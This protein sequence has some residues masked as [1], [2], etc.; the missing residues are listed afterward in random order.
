MSINF[1]ILICVISILIN[2]ILNI[3]GIE[4]Y[5]W[6]IDHSMYFGQRLLEG[7]F[8]W[9][10]EFNDRLLVEQ[11]LF[12]LPASY[13]SVSVWLL[14]S[15]AFVVLGSW[16]CFVLVDD[17]LSSSPSIPFKERKFVAIISV[18]SMVYLFTFLPGGLHHVNPTSASFALV[19]LAL[20]VRSLPDSSPIRW[21][22]FFISALSA[23]ISIGIRPYFFLAL[24]FT[25]TLLIKNRT[26]TWIGENSAIFPLG[27]WI[28][29]VSIFGILINMLPYIITGDLNV[30]NAGISML[31]QDI[32]PQRF[33]LTVYRIL[34]VFFNQNLFIIL[35]TIISTVSIFYALSMLIDFNI[36]KFKR[37]T[38]NDIVVLILVL[39]IFLLSLI[40]IKH[41]HSHYLQMFAPFIGIGVGFFFA[42]CGQNSAH[43]LQVFSKKI[44]VFAIFVVIISI[45]LPLMSDIKKLKDKKDE[46]YVLQISALVSEQPKDQR[47]FLFINDMRSH[48]KL[49]EPRHGFPHAANS[50]HIMMGH[51]LKIM[52]PAYI[53]HPTNSFEYCRALEEKGPTL[54]FTRNNN[55]LRDF[56]SSCLIKSSKYRLIDE[57]INKISMFIRN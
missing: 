23:S 19:C 33:I 13:S 29:L 12:A 11:I 46:D 40:L 42:L 25:V 48:W 41:F 51:W 10:K 28:I 1:I 30:F 6:D 14:F 9:T 15:T 17:I 43:K 52:M 5:D 3:R 49:G 4:G 45:L 56:K 2:W 34:T 50:Q 31:S 37:K 22:P 18:V 54:V 57:S 24:I 26:R 16:A 36:E 39:P 8:I 53:G 47:D 38:L 35:L 7:E 27:V 32:N 55:K 20:I 21:Y 44:S